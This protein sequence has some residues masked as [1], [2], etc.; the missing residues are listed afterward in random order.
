[1][2]DV[3][4]FFVDDLNDSLGDVGFKSCEG[5]DFEVLGDL[6]QEAQGIRS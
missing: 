6:F 1:M 2:A 5:D 4:P 3:F